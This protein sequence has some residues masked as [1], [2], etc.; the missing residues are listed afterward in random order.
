MKPNSFL[1]CLFK[2]HDCTDLTSNGKEYSYCHR[3]GRIKEIRQSYVL[4]TR[5]I[6]DMPRRSAGPTIPIDKL[7]R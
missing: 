3:C 5:S 1:V 7:W 6:D 2:G 4:A